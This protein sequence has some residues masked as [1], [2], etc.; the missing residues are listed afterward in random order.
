MD[1]QAS[2]AFG[3]DVDES[4]SGPNLSFA[5]PF[6]GRKLHLEVRLRWTK[7]R[8]VFLLCFQMA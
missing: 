3:H 5:A 4:R 6:E 2:W 1:V 7:A 8:L